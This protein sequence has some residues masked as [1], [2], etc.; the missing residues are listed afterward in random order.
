MRQVITLDIKRHLNNSQI[1]SLWLDFERLSN[2]QPGLAIYPLGGAEGCC[3][4]VVE[5]QVK[6]DPADDSA[7]MELANQH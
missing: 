4:N 5:V 6:V 7:L 2:Q 1:H 3:N